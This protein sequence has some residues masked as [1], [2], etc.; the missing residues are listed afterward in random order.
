MS[1][2]GASFGSLEYC[3]IGSN[4][5]TAPARLLYVQEDQLGS[6]IMMAENFR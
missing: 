5:S 1:V 4:G 3:R 2:V 6:D